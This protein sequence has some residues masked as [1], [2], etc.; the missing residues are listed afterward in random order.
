M[1]KYIVITTIN[2]MLDG[3]SRH[4]CGVCM[5]SNGGGL[6]LFT[7]VSTDTF[8][9]YEGARYAANGIAKDEMNSIHHDCDIANGWSLHFD[10]SHNVCE[11]LRDEALNYGNVTANDK[12]WLFKVDVHKV[13]VEC[14]TN[15]WTDDFD[16]SESIG[17]GCSEPTL[18]TENGDNCAKCKHIEFC[19]EGR[20]ILDDR[21]EM[22]IHNDLS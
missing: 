18:W 11:C 17:S 10:N 6:P 19:G 13:L 7:I 3:C 4:P 5:C 22:D 1:E 14:D 9:T 2:S 12:V 21:K 16:G 20:A 15:N 8:D